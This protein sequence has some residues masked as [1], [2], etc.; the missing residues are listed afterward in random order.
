[1]ATLSVI[2]KEAGWKWAG[3]TFGYMTALA[4]IGAVATYQVGNWMMGAG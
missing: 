4:W 3:L 2:K 1:M